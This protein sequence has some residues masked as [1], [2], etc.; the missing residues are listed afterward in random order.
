MKEIV[1]DIKEE[2]EYFESFGICIAVYD[3]WPLT[4]EEEENMKNCT[5][6][7]E[8]KNEWPPKP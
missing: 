8:S 1:L 7:T 4:D 3:K 2:Q 5:I 6:E